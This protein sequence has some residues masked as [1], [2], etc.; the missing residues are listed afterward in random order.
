MGL[1]RYRPQAAPRLAARVPGVFDERLSLPKPKPRAPQS[2]CLQVPAIPSAGSPNLADPALRKP[3]W[4]VHFL[5]Y[6]LKI[7]AT[8]LAA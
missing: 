5:T 6:G 1:P 2:P 4:R 3:R 7:R 8:I